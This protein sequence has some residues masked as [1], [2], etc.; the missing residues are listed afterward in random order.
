MEVD[1][2]TFALLQK[3][4][5]VEKRRSLYGSYENY[6]EIEVERLVKGILQLVRL[7]ELLTGQVRTYRLCET[8]HFLK[9]KNKEVSILRFLQE[10]GYPCSLK[11]IFKALKPDSPVSKPH[12]RTILVNLSNLGYV[13][14]PERG[15]Y[16][17]TGPG[18]SL[19]EA[20]RSLV[21][22]ILA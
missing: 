10:R 21:E 6:Y 17:I 2:E 13:T 1:S 5:K 3:N 16:R 22:E 9:G 20:S 15:L 12:L 11:S 18:E 8:H 4:I 7:R 19:V 14:Q